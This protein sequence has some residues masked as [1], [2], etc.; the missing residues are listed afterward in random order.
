MVTVALNSGGA[1]AVAAHMQERGR[2]FP[3]VLDESGSVASVWGV[4]G[5]PTTFFVDAEGTVRNVTV[6]YTSWLGL[7]LRLWWAEQN[8]GG[9]ARCQTGLTGAK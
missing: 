7:R 3:V 9:R 6:G 8:T 2:A 4:R 1:D 5:V